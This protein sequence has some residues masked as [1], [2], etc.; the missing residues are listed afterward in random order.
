MW[1]DNKPIESEENLVR[2]TIRQ[3]LIDEETNY[4][5]DYPF[6]HPE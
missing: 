1:T 4:D 5:N 3:E 6:M 2:R